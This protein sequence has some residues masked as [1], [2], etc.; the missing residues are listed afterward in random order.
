MSKSNKPVEGSRGYWPR[1]RAKKIYP[2]LKHP[3][4]LTDSK[5]VSI[6]EYAGYKAGMTQV[7][8]IDQRK[9]SPTHNQLVVRPVTVLE[10]PP[11]VVCGLKLYKQTP[12]G[13][14]GRTIVWADKLDKNLSRKTELPKE[15]KSK[16][17]LAAAEKNISNVSDV[18]L[19]VHT[20]PKEAGFGKKT[21][22]IFEIALSGD[23][24]AKW[25]F[26]KQ[27]LGGSL[28]PEDIFK[29]GEYIDVLAITTGK[30]YQGPVKRFGIKVRSRKNKG[31]MRHVGSLGPYH[32]ARV[33]P[34]AVPEAGQ[35]GFQS[36]TEYNK[37]ILK[38]GS[39]SMTPK[40]GWLDYGQVDGHYML[41][42]GSVP[43]HKK[44]LIMLRKAIR[45]RDK[46]F[47]VKVESISLD[48]QQ[49]V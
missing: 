16:E 29:E 3:K 31:K 17:K 30:G 28:K 45:F 47:P 38:I 2:R 32:P 24:A 21:P 27:K 8:L 19:L 18:R 35:L 13:L 20:Q 1:K 14:E 25:D 46:E 43:G 36:R 33:L 5:N 26:A 15:T 41:V 42:S 34:G 48:S 44:R 11:L 49:G 23:F 37:R 6:I 22:E 12:Y 4:V 39:G 40:G 9:G 10:C 7:S